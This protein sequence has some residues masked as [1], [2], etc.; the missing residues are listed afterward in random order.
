M[1]L[2]VSRAI[3]EDV[4]GAQREDLGL[5]GMP[6][7]SQVLCLLQAWSSALQHFVG[8]LDPETA[9]DFP[10]V[11]HLAKDLFESAV[12][13]SGARSLGDVTTLQLL[14]LPLDFQ[15]KVN[16]SQE[17]LREELTRLP[18][19]VADHMVQLPTTRA[20]L[21]EYTMESIISNVDAFAQRCYRD[22]DREPNPMLDSILRALVQIR[23]FVVEIQMKEAM[24]SNRARVNIPTGGSAN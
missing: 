5:M 13:M 10:T 11:V 16:E 21:L 6:N 17:V 22:R 24:V 19:S 15:D 4:K 3:I 12:Y 9:D 8:L 7:V 2:A 23:V 18:R 14:T 20:L 1:L